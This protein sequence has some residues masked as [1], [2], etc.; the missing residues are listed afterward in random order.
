MTSTP[1]TPPPSAP[2]S[3]PHPGKV[4]RRFVVLALTTLVLACTYLFFVRQRLNSWA[5][6][7]RVSHS[8]RSLP[9]C[10]RVEIFRLTPKKPAD[11]AETQPPAA[12]STPEFPFGTNRQTAIVEASATLTGAD[13][14]AFCDL[15]KKQ[16]FG[17]NFLTL[18]HTPEFGFRAYSGESVVFATSI[19]FSARTFYTD[20]YGSPGLWGLDVG[21]DSAKS[22]RQLLESRLNKPNP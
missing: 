10:D 18:R 16:H 20:I 19:S 3:S 4:R 1:E 14:A 2:A 5:L 15:W 8:L 7:W 21:S 6:D 13:A 22:L 9:T 17:E 11:T 12:P